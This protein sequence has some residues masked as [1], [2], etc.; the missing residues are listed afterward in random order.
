MNDL[1]FLCSKCAQEIEVPLSQAGSWIVC[2]LCKEVVRAP[3]CPST[4]EPMPEQPQKAHQQSNAFAS[5]G[6]EITTRGYNTCSIRMAPFVVGILCFVL[7]FLHISCDGNKVMQL[8]GVQ[9]VTGFD[10]K[11]PMTEETSHNP[12]ERLAVIALVA[13]AVG[14]AFC[15][16]AG[17]ARAIVAAFSGGAALLALLLLKSRMDAQILKEASGMPISLDYL[18]GFWAVCLSSLAG[19]I[20][21][22]MRVKHEAI[23]L[24][25][26]RHNAVSRPL[27][28]MNI[29]STFTRSNDRCAT[30]FAD[31]CKAPLPDPAITYSSCSES[32]AAISPASAA[33]DQVVTAS[34]DALKALATVALEKG[35]AAS[36]D[37]LQAFKLFAFNPVAGLSVAF[38]SLGQAR[39]LGAGI[40]FGA[41]FGLSVLFGTYRLLGEWGRPNGFSGFVKI[42][43][44]SVVPF[45]S[46]FGASILG[47]KVCRA[48]G[49]FG[50]DCFIV[51]A[52]SLPFGFVALLAA[53]LGIGNME[54]IAV[55]IIFA[56][57]LTILMLF[58]G[59]TRICKISEQLAT[60]A[61]PLMLIASA[62]FSKI[63]YTT[64]LK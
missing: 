22:I 38:E 49:G 2:P 18:L 52:S 28:S 6:R 55:L 21:S 61:V 1:K 11:N 46:L 37:A 13:L 45:I 7:P 56:V 41:L 29:P 5:T 44:V 42:L 3:D 26:D 57:C 48:E 8:T 51:G 58:A 9:L 10:M 32:V 17:R 36:K 54:V 23:D 53:I 50:H 20:L 43:V 27:N 4:V 63:I 25:L 59:L 33:V 15:V 24:A 60:I 39:A 34:K 14:A 40:I 47:R 30:M 64:I 62:W 35:M 12:S 16:H 19:T 31:K